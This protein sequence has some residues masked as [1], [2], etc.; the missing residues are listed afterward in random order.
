[1]NAVRMQ[2]TAVGCKLTVRHLS[3]SGAASRDFACLWNVPRTSYPPVRKI[4]LAS[5]KPPIDK[6]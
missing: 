1:M 6:G 3:A 2:S 4:F 5:R